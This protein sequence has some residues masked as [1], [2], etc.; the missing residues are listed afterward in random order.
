MTPTGS[1]TEWIVQLKAGD[2]RASQQLWER[3]IDRLVR[4]ATQKLGGTP[5]RADDEEDVALS[6]FNGFFRGV[7]ESRFPQLDNR[8]DL[9]QLLVMLTGRRAV[10]HR[11][12]ELAA[13]RGG[14]AVRGE[15]VFADRKAGESYQAGISQIMDGEPSPE[16]AAEFAEEFEWLLASLADDTL[17]RIVVGKMEGYTNEELANEL[18]LHVGSIER[19]LRLIR[20]TWREGNIT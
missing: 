19:K 1:V 6:A 2:P 4:L 11:R 15:S 17:R 3:Y 8:D 7:E 16:F 10:D 9:W 5:R 13:K 12:R 18:N 14:G 20:R